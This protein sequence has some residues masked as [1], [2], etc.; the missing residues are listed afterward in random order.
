MK[1]NLLLHSILLSS[2]LIHTACVHKNIPNEQ[3]TNQISQSDYND[4]TPLPVTSD[5][6]RS[7]Q[8]LTIQGQR[9]S[10]TKRNTGLLF[11]QYPDKI[12]L[13]Q[14]FGKDCPYC[15]KEMPTINTIRSHYG[16]NIQV[17]AIQVEDKMSADTASR[18]M[19]QY[20][21][22]YPIIERNEAS[23]LLLF[24]N[25]IYGWTGGLPFMQLI[26]NG[27]TEYTFPESPSYE[28]LQESVESL[29]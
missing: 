21:M 22:N 1:K 16:D 13:L 7:Q 12:I 6:S 28:E 9:I 15:F 4:A 11:P 26:K 29:L 2:I 3:T 23:S 24:L 18:L 27:V 5:A 20:Q 25:E 8:L 19:H 17:I 14:V 10:V